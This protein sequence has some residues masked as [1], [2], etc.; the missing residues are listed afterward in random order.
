MAIVIEDAVYRNVR[1]K[2]WIDNYFSDEHDREVAWK[3]FFAIRNMFPATEEILRG[4]L[5]AGG[6]QA[7]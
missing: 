3:T 5:I 2:F 7:G 4:E 6:H 1:L